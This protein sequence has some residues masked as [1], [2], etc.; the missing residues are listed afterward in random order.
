MPTRRDL[1][2]LLQTPFWKWTVEQWD[3]FGHVCLACFGLYVLLTSNIVV[4]ALLLY[5]AA[6]VAGAWTTRDRP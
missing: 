2:Q 6:G 3:L 1:V 5:V 4:A